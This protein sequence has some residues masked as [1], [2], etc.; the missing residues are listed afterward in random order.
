MFAFDNRTIL[1]VQIFVGVISTIYSFFPSNSS[2]KNVMV[3]YRLSNSAY[4][5]GFLL[6]LYQDNLPMSV[7]IVMSNTLIFLAFAFFAITATQLYGYTIERRFTISIAVLHVASF[8]IFTYLYP[9][10]FA[11]ICIVSC[12]IIALQLKSQ[13]ILNRVKYKHA[14]PVFRMLQL[15]QFGYI[16]LLIFRISLTWMFYR[17]IESIFSMDLASTIIFLGTI[18]YHLSMNLIFIITLIIQYDEQAKKRIELLEGTHHEL[19]ALNSLQSQVAATGGLEQLYEAMT[20]FI[21][22][23]FLQRRLVF[24]SRMPKMRGS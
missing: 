20:S 22:N 3:S 5:L 9:N 17:K 10:T 19:T 11:R 1:F 21:K 6:L 24:I 7:T 4:L 16:A 8:I 12:A 18:A 14:T 2:R 23:F 13:I 15:T